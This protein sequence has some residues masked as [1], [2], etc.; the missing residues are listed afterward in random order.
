MIASYLSLTW[1]E[2]HS[3]LMFSSRKMLPG[4]TFAI[5]C[6]LAVRHDHS[7]GSSVTS[8]VLVLD[9][10]LTADIPSFK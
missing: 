8:E 5:A 6:S 10:G 1:A 4:I 9:P 7:S 2:Q 3:V